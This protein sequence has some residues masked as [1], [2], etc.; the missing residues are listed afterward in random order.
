MRKHS[1]TPPVA[2][3]VGGG[4]VLASLSTVL[5]LSVLVPL[6]GA[7][8]TLLHVPA[9]CPFYQLTGLPCPGCG[10]TRAFVY[11]GHGQWA[12]S[13]RWHPLG[14]LLYA[15][16]ILWWART[17]WCLIRK[18]PMQALPLAVSRAALGLVLLTGAGRIGWLLVHHA[19]W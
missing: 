2:G 15:A 6:P 19:R 8:G 18:R 13:L 10:L 12:D 1:Y 14:L 7:D 3:G 4:F 16:C 9:F 11:I 5:L 17:L